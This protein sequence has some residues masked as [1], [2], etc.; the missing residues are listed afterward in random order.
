MST[1]VRL[2]T[3]RYNTVVIP[4]DDGGLHWV[5]YLLAASTDSD[6]I[7]LAGH[8]RITI[9]G[10]GKKE[11]VGYHL[12]TQKQLSRAIEVFRDLNLEKALRMREKH[13]KYRDLAADME[14][15]HYERLKDVDKI[16]E[17]RGDTH[18]EIMTHLR[19]VMSHATNIG[20]ILLQWNTGSEA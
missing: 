10:D 13:N 9:S 20:R 7:V 5:V 16:L 12:K 15:H 2:C 8:H 3:P 14:K 1:K 19:N 11:L 4:A 6:D 18:M 17:S